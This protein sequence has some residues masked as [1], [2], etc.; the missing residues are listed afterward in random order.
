MLISII[1]L[2]TSSIGLSLKGERESFVHDSTDI[3]NYFVFNTIN[4]YIACSTLS[5]TAAKICHTYIIAML[6]SLIILLLITLKVCLCVIWWKGRRSR[7]L[8]VERLLL[9]L[10]EP[11]NKKWQ[12]KYLWGGEKR[13][14]SV[15]TA[16]EERR[17]LIGNHCSWER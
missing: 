5:L 15:V 2:F 10:N 12:V 17:W 6:S 9:L 3:P 8:R 7:R 4:S 14:K 16:L 11:I 1:Y 13:N